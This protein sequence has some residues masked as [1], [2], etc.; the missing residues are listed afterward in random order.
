V[1][2]YA[3]FI[4]I[5]HKFNNKELFCKK[6]MSRIGKLPIE[7][8]KNVTITLEN[9]KIQVK[10]PHGNLSQTIPKEIKV[11]YTE[12]LITL[13]KIA[14]TQSGKEKYGL[15]RALIN[16]MII[17]V[18]KK[19]EKKLQMIGVGYRAQIKG[20]E[21]TLNVGYSHPIL[22]IVPENIDVIVEA[23]INL[24]ITGIDKEKV[25]VLASKIRATRPPEPYKG[26]GIRY[27]DEI[28]LRKAGKSGK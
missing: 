4:K 23:N 20:K 18:S 21:L 14:E 1:K 10:G 22:F 12:N 8:P 16:N 28:V 24:R 27:N 26:K 17:G 9:S 11:S 5:L 6:I 2:F 25:G 3:I 15:T 19:F 7:I 13:E